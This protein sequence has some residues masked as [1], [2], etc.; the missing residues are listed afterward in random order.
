L[1][2]GERARREVDRL[3]A[4]WEPSGLG[5]D[6]KAELARRMESEARR[7]GMDGL[8]KREG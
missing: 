6:V 4:A 7:A 5:D 2:L 3:V 1:T 8:P